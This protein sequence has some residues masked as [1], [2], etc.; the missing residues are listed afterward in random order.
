MRPPPTRLVNLG[1]LLL[2]G[3]LTITGL[4]SLGGGT[5]ESQPVFQAH[6]LAGSLLVLLLGFK[7]AIMV[8]SLR[9]QRHGLVSVALSLGGALMLFAACGAA[10]LWTIG[11]APLMGLAGLTTLSWHV[12][13]G[14]A[15]LP[16]M[17][18]HAWQRQRLRL[19]PHSPG[20]RHALRLVGL[21]GAAAALWATQ[22]VVAPWL[23]KGRRYTGSREVASFAGNAFPVTTW[24]PEAP[25][26]LR[27][28][29]YR[30]R[31]TGLVEQPL[32]L[33]VEELQAMAQREMVAT[34]D[35]TAGWYSTQRWGGA[36]AS[37]LLKAA[38]LHAGA[39]TVRFISATGY[40]ASYSLEEASQ[41]LLAGQVGHE[42]LLHE[43]GAPCRLVAPSR[44]GLD[45]V[46][47]VVEIRV[48]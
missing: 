13:L 46:K 27:A 29:R 28:E 48:V 11:L 41:T 20:R 31:V 3:L 18:V 12:Y 24:F 8:R 39:S 34:L 36:A 1:L 33:R 40:S 7:V 10:V 15:L 2:L 44:R 38:R 6:R 9:A 47:W 37:D 42:P 14:L 43:H 17:L 4:L 35:C 19:G 22:Q 21:G 23:Q 26:P 16:V 5:V 32:V 45:W 25:P 30:L